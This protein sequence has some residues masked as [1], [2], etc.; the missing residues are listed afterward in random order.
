MQ[1]TQ[2]SNNKIALEN[3][4]HSQKLM[5]QQYDKKLTRASA[6]FRKLE[7]GDS[8]LIENVYRN[9]KGGR[10]QDKWLGPYSIT[11]VT[12]TNVHI[13]RNKSIKRVKRSTVKL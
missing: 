9:K 12:S 13:L 5:K 10:L 2:E 11:K 4:A 6:S 3:L 8:V 1:D 7:K